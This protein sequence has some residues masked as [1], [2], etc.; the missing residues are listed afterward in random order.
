MQP[1]RQLGLHR[2]RQLRPARD[3][4]LR[5]LRDHA[6]RFTAAGV[7]ALGK[8]PKLTENLKT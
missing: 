5:K 6:L 2:D 1:F 7:G 4:G 3:A 8:K